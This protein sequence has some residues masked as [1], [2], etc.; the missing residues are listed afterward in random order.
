MKKGRGRPREFSE[1]EVLAKALEAF[2]ECGFEATSLD[3]LSAA[4]G[5]NRPSLY[6]SFGDKETIYLKA[7]NKWA[8]NLRAALT[9]SLNP[10]LPVED[11]LLQFYESAIEL[12]SSG[13]GR[14][15]LA[16]CTAPS[17]VGEHPAVRQVLVNILRE[18]DQGL[19]AYLRHAQAQGGLSAHLDPKQMA[20]LA[21]AILHSLAVRARAGETRQDLLSL[22]R[23][24]VALINAPP[25][26]RPSSA[27]ATFPRDSIRP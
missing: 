4:T 16:V 8:Q 2:W 5:L 3:D 11:A 1:E 12:Y 6:A 27:P 24:A 7:L 17:V 19:E 14:G 13:P 23:V 20:R 15:C 25:G 18:L 10:R 9:Q 21:A 22:A 26:A